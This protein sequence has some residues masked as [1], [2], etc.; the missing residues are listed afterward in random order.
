MTYFSEFDI[1]GTLNLFSNWSIDFYLSG[2]KVV[3][4]NQQVVVIGNATAAL[5][6]LVSVG[7]LAPGSVGTDRSFAPFEHPGSQNWHS[8]CIL[9]WPD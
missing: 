3:G 9:E 5:E 8:G 7:V 2:Y 6:A 1:M 4:Y